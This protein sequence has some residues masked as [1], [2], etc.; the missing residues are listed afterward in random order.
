MSN[1]TLYAI[2][3]NDLDYRFCEG[4]ENVENN[5]YNSWIM[6]PANAF[7][8]LI[9]IYYSCIGL[10]RERNHVISNEMRYSYMMLIICGIGSFLFHSQFIYIFRLMDEIPMIILATTS[11]WVYSRYL[12][13]Y[14]I[15]VPDMIQFFWMFYC[16]S[17]ISLTPFISPT[18]FRVG[19][20]IPIIYTFLLL[21]SFVLC[22]REL[23]QWYV[24]SILSI[25]IGF[26]CWNVDNIYCNSIINMFKFHLWWHLFVGY[27]AYTLI[28]FSFYF[29]L[30]RK[31]YFSNEII[32]M[33]QYGIFLYIDTKPNIDK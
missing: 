20:G 28:E 14:T 2:W 12:L 24:V 23:I 21:K 16:V 7:S 13:H 6:E 30:R 4:Y 29:H 15:C 27:A 10:Y 11:A 26:I 22:Y 32:I 17:L 5:N 3:N 9:F 1:Y 31:E 25:S 19:F 8:S 33:K 18:I